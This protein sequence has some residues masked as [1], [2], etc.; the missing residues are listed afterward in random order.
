M[1][2]PNVNAAGEP[3]PGLF[4]SVKNHPIPAPAS[5]S[6]ARLVGRRHDSAT[7]AVIRAQPAA[8]SVTVAVHEVPRSDPPG[9]DRALANVSGPKAAP[10]TPS[11]TAPALT[12]IS[13]R[14]DLLTTES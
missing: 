4:H 1:I 3:R 7:P 6:P 8:S 10:S 11:A 2:R 14:Q 9:A 13:V 5:S 12:L